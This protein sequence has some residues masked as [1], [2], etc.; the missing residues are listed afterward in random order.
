MVNCSHCGKELDRKVFCNN[1]HKVMY[2]TSP[3]A[4]AGKP[5]EKIVGNIREVTPNRPT[6]QDLK[7]IEKIKF[8]PV[9]K[10]RKK[11]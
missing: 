6:E 11:K 3:G 7:E 1:S 5:P 10:P 8:T 4:I 2:H 9:P